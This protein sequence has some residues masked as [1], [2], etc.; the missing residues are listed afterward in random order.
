MVSTVKQ[1]AGDDPG[2]V[3]GQ[4]RPPRGG[5]APRGRVEPVAVQGGAD[6][7]R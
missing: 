2:G 5:R 6:G 3:L 7:G 1:V 4:E